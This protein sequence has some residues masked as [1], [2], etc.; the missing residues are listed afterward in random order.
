MR[1]GAQYS[2]VYVLSLWMSSIQIRGLTLI[3]EI[4]AFMS[5]AGLVVIAERQQ[6]VTL[7]ARPPLD[8]SLYFVLI[9]SPICLSDATHWSKDTL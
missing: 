2:A 5:V 3:I 8:V 1:A 6:L 9:S 7:T 4:S